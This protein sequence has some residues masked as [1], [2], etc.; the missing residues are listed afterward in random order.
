MHPVKNGGITNA[1]ETFDARQK[2]GVM[3]ALEKV[4]RD[5]GYILSDIF[6]NVTGTGKAKKT[7]KPS[8]ATYANPADKTATW[9]GRGR[10]PKW[11]IDAIVA[12]KTS[13]SMR[14]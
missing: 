14:L 8:T 11:Y 2:E 5:F 1:I 12:G 7:R 9:S 3:V 4:A 13:D 6:A 10:K